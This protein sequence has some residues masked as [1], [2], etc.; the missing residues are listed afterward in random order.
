MERWMIVA[1]AVV[2]V[3]PLVLMVAF[4]GTNRADSRGRRINRTWR[5]RRQET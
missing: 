3:L 2:V 1:A 4:N 5:V